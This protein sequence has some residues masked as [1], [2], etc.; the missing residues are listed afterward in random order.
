MK[1]LFYYN[2]KIGKIGLAEERG[3]I[4]NLL[5]IDSTPPKN[6]K[7][8]ESEILKEAYTQLEQY[9]KR[10]RSDFSIPINPSGDKISQQI[11]IEVMNIKYGHT[12]SYKELAD[13]L[14]MHTRTVTSVLYKNP[15]PIIIPCHRVISLKEKVTGYVGDIKIKENLLTLENPYIFDEEAKFFEARYGGCYKYFV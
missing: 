10:T 5:F 15:I 3:L 14:D 2:T 7:I 6:C 8:F 13:K 12:I 11:L 1:N 4:T 9:L